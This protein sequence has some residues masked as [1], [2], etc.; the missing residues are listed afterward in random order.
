MTVVSCCV[1]AWRTDVGAL[2]SIY[3]WSNRKRVKT[4][5]ITSYECSCKLNRFTIVRRSYCNFNHIDAIIIAAEI[6][7][8]VFAASA[9]WLGVVLSAGID[10]AM[11]MCKSYC[12]HHS[13]VWMYIVV[14]DNNQHLRISFPRFAMILAV[15]RRHR[16]YSTYTDIGDDNNEDKYHTN[17]QYN[18][19]GIHN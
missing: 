19:A 1:V 7:T 10:R 14:D 6:G 4:T 17:R 8:G 3:R 5:N 12:Q 9:M 16:W 15:R 13:I 2:S 11:Q 18:H